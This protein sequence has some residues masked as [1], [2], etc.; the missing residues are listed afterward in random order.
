MKFWQKAKKL[1]RAYLIVNQIYIKNREKFKEKIAKNCSATSV[2]VYN[3]AK[4]ILC[5]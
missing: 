3:K 2:D 5:E 1:P 4:F